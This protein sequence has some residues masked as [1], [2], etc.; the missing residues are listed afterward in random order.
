[1]RIAFFER[2][3]IQNSRRFPEMNGRT[4]VVLGVSE[5][6]GHVFGYSVFL[7]DKV[8]LVSFEA[9]EVVGTGELVDR[10]VFYDEADRIRV[11][12]RDG[13]GEVIE[14]EDS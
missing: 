9:D 7:N 12:V 6:D 5:E 4:G 14:S 2:V 11:R 3:V 13:Y 8:E 1:M 10:S